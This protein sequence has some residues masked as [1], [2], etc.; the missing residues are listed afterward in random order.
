MEE[1]FERLCRNPTFL[2]DADEILAWAQEESRISGI[3]PALPFA[4]PLELHAQYGIRDIQAAFDQA[5]PQSAGQRGTGVLHFN[6]IKAYVILITFQKTEKEFSPSTMY[7]DYPISRDLL[8]WESQSNTARGLRHR[9]EPDR[10]PGRG[11]TILAFARSQKNRNGCTMPFIY[12]G[13]ID[14]LSHESERPIKMIWRC[15]IPCRRRCL[16]RIS[17]AGEGRHTR[18]TWRALA[19]NCERIG[20]SV[21]PPS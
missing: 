5:T 9:P 6:D 19:D 15:G 14:R 1:S 10:P 18:N 20:A 2:R 11:Y 7:A 4:C 17:G 16:R 12:L 21:W 13:P 3:M 8:H